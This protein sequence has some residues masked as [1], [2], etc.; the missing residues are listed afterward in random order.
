MQPLFFPPLLLKPISSV[1]PAPPLTAAAQLP[2]SSHLLVWEQVFQQ[3]VFVSEAAQGV[4]AVQ[5]VRVDVVG[6]RQAADGH[7]PGNRLLG[8]RFVLPP[9]GWNHMAT[10]MRQGQWPFLKKNVKKIPDSVFSPV[11]TA[12]WKSVTSLDPPHVWKE[13]HTRSSQR[14]EHL[15]VVL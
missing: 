8:L 12:F 6:G 2:P 5:D 7:L 9:S 1:S 4:H 10:H 11:F 15:S 3:L 14:A 13:T